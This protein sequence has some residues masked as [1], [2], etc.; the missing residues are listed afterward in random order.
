MNIDVDEKTA[1]KLV[2]KFGPIR[3]VSKALESRYGREEIEIRL[4][5]LDKV[6]IA[7]LR[8]LV[9]ASTH[10][11]KEKMIKR[12]D[13]YVGV[14]ENPG[15]KIGRLNLLV[16]GLKTLI[17]TAPHKWLAKEEADGMTCFYLV[18][19]IKYTPADTSKERPAS[20][21]VRLKYFHDGQLKTA[22]IGYDSADVKNQTAA[23]CLYS[24][25]YRL[26][27]PDDFEK[28]V[29][30]WDR[31]QSI[32]KLTGAQFTGTGLAYKADG[33]RN[34]KG[35][36][37]A[38]IKNDLP[39]R[40]VMDHVFSGEDKREGREVLMSFWDGF[41]DDDSDFD[42][43]SETAEAPAHPYLT[44]FDMNSHRFVDVHV[45]N[46]TE[47]VWN[48]GLIDSLVLDQ[49]TK[50][51]VLMLIEGADARM[52][53]IIA[54]K[55]SGIIIAASG[56]PGV[57]KTLTAQIFS[58]KTQRPIY[59]VQCS[60]LGTDEELIEKKLDI[61]LERASRWGAILQIDEADVYIHERGE[62]IQQ[63]AIVG[64][65][66]RLLEYYRGV[67]FMTT[68]RATIIDDA[69][70]SR[71]TAH[72]EY[73]MPEVGELKAIW[74]IIAKING[75]NLTPETISEFVAALPGISGRDVTQLSKMLRL[76]SGWTKQ[77]PGV[78]M[79]KFVAKYSP[80]TTRGAKTAG[81]L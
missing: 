62:S 67:L 58:E 20:V 55:S 18:S 50:D 49:S 52:S 70:L 7:Y 8:E 53:D 9:S 48:P 57:G 3:G 28:N 60:Q 38:L 51:L 65:F 2:E 78:E 13:S 23:E 44:C 17:E 77:A 75:L 79:L 25:G 63:N 45:D 26:E 39:G 74:R 5:V 37:V 69:I 41:D 29:A 1:R 73:K 22:A 35:E 27:S 10:K 21:D 71:C 56:P 16:G 14:L 31:M 34:W 46:L 76:R 61:V 36:T 12:I 64:V 6:K 66:L 4:T 68:N 33:S 32:R 47:W 40:L 80:I 72:I 11:E 59:A 15:K 24:S 81:T 42:T 19:D 54:G 30:E 43:D